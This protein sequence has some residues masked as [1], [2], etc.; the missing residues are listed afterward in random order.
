MSDDCLFCKIV[1]GDIPSARVYEDDKVIAFNDINPQA[2][3]HILIIP[4]EHIATT[5]DLSS[6]HNALLGHMI[7]TAKQI[8]HDQGIAEDGYRLIFNCNEQ[9]GQTVYHIHL[10]LMGGRQ[11]RG[12]G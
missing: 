8:A 2:P 12:L 5:N 6:E 7:N 9:G 10:H 3:I 1:S 4:R 11:L